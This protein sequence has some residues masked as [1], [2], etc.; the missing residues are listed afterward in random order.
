MAEALPLSTVA[1]IEFLNQRPLWQYQ[2]KR[3]D[4]TADNPTTAT[5]L[6]RLA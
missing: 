4:S 6:A 1:G 5:P 2:R 3:Q